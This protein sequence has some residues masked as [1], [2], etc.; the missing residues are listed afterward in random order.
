MAAIVATTQRV[1]AIKSHSWRALAMHRTAV[2]GGVFRPDAQ[3]CL[4]AMFTLDDAAN[5]IGSTIG[6][7]QQQ[8]PLVFRCKQR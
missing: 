3:V 7:R 5:L 6:E 8:H 1:E 2:A 4:G